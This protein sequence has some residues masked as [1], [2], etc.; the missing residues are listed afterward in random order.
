MTQPSTR[1]ATPTRRASREAAPA[2]VGDPTDRPS[3]ASAAPV[4][5]E[6]SATQPVCRY[7][8]EDVAAAGKGAT[9]VECRPC[10]ALRPASDASA[11]G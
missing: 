1:R 5:S 3:P 7:A 11:S 8:D 4:S 2:V 10:V 9:A 6:D